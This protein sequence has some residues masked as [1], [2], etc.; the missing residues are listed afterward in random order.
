[1]LQNGARARTR[2]PHKTEP[3]SNSLLLLLAMPKFSIPGLTCSLRPRSSGRLRT[4]EGSAIRTSSNS[5][6]LLQLGSKGG[7]TAAGRTQ[8]NVKLANGPQ[9]AVLSKRFDQLGCIC[10]MLSGHHQV[11]LFH[12]PTEKN[13]GL[14]KQLRNVTAQ[15]SSSW[16]EPWLKPKT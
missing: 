7:S 4:S 15:S 2:H 6:R 11:L 14:A 12:G 16:I 8:K 9:V 13:L 3:H 5:W 1:M 10:H